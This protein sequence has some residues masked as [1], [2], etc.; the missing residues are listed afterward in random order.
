M[1]SYKLLR[2]IDSLLDD[3]QGE[4]LERSVDHFMALNN[5]LIILRRKSGLGPETPNYIVEIIV[6]IEK[7]FCYAHSNIGTSKSYKP[8]FALCKNANFINNHTDQIFAFWVQIYQIANEDFAK[9]FEEL[10]MIDSLF[11]NW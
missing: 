3:F 6:L 5:H 11:F 1:F 8:N 2:I 4:G 10:F 9:S 7:H